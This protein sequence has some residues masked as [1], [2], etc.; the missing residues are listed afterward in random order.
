VYNKIIQ[1]HLTKALK[2][3]STLHYKARISDTE[4]V[5]NAYANAYTITNISLKGFNGL[6]YL[7]YQYN[8]LLDILNVNPAM[9]IIVTVIGS[10][11]RP[12]IL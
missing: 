2:S 1:E 5:F 6:S 8:K 9:M 4:N 12:I 3:Y 11:K 7:R 10:Q